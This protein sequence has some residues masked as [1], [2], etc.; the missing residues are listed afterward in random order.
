MG[1][2]FG[3]GYSG[4][5]SHISGNDMGS[6]EQKVDKKETQIREDKVPLSN[7]DREVLKELA[8]DISNYR[9][10]DIKKKGFRSFVKNFR[11]MTKLLNSKNVSGEDINLVLRNLSLALVRYVDINTN[12]VKISNVNTADRKKLYSL[13]L[14]V[15]NIKIGEYDTKTIIKLFNEYEKAVKLLNSK[16][17]DFKKLNEGY[18]NLSK[19]IKKLHKNKGL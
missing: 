18:I 14:K 3:G 11:K 4:G 5:T 12:E 15:E 16:K 2:S 17:T 9:L 13:V 1:G 6:K 10:K 8:E 7:Y 19:L